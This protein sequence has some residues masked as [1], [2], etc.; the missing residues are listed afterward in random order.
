MGLAARSQH[1]E[2]TL[3]PCDVRV[4]A[5]LVPR[6]MS[7]EGNFG[8]SVSTDGATIVVGDDYFE[9][10]GRR[11]GAAFVFE[12][13]QNG[14]W[15]QVQLIVPEAAEGRDSAGFDVSVDGDLMAIGAPFTGDGNVGCVYVYCRDENG[16]WVLDA[17]I[18]PGLRYSTLPGWGELHFGERVELSEGALYVGS[19][20]THRRVYRRIS[21]GEW[22]FDRRFISEIASEQGTAGDLDGNTFVLPE[23]GGIDVFCWDA[24]SGWIKAERIKSA[25][26]HYRDISLHGSLLLLGTWWRHH[27][28]PP[29]AH[30]VVRDPATGRWSHRVRLNG[31]DR[32]VRTD[33]RFGHRVAVE[34]GIAVIGAPHAIRWASRTGAV[35]VFTEDT[36]GMWIERANLTPAD[37]V[38][39]DQIGWDVD[40]AGDLVVVGSY[41]GGA[42]YVYQVPLDCG[43]V[44][45]LEGTECPTRGT[46]RVSWV[47]ATS[48]STITV[49]YSGQMGHKEIPRGY[50]CAYTQLNLGRDPVRV[51][52]VGQSDAAGT[53]WI[54]LTGSAV[55]CDGFLQLVDDATCEVSNVVKIMP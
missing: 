18:H 45:T 39:N 10:Q 34:P 2:A 44:L 25:G 30:L 35:Y 28:H 36:H 3:G 27:M 22:Q 9:T 24:T 14:L 55:L 19:H 33:D 5:K 43:P 48:D 47:G 1:A 53:G 8:R 16:T 50:G 26:A 32:G 29:G 17:T 51:A 52:G 11:P 46:A 13:D 40:C 21:P 12:R 4:E 31:L 49:L 6:E 37:T 15:Q 7:R 54:E 20:F 41:N 42:A 23:P 38:E